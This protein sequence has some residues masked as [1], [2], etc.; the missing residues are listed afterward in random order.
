[1]DLQRAFRVCNVDVEYVI[2]EKKE[3]FF[4]RVVIVE[5]RR[6]INY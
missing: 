2:R 4:V 1:M 5:R 3:K 6:K